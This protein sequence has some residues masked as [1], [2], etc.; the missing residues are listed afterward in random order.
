MA[1]E[2]KTARW[3]L[4]LGYTAFALVAFV[5]CLMFTFPYDAVRSRLVT[6]AA[7]QGL[8]VRIG[9]LRPGLS[10]V[11]ATNVRV[12]KPPSPLGADAVAALARGESGGMGPDELGEALTFDSVALRPSLFPPGVV[13]KLKGMGGTVNVHVGGLSGTA[14]DVDVDGVQAGGGNLPAYTGVDMEGT[15]NAKVSLQAPGTMVRGQPV[16]WSQATGTVVMDTQGLTIKGGKAAIPMGGGPAMPM[17]L[18]RVLLGELK[19]DIQFDK[20]LGTVRDLN[21]KSEDLEGSGTGT[22]KLGRRLEYSEL[23]LD[24][25]LKFEQAFQQRLG[26][27]A[28]AVN[29]LPADR[30]NPGW[31]G[32]RLT[33]MVGSPRFA[34][35]H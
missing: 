33:G 10:G 11:T 26:P 19:G 20:G 17:D 25:R 29:M 5:L 30:D 35:K 7:A 4:I 2:T 23:A 27:L 8:A 18:P 12:S 24:V 14:L 22:V 1:S 6:E 9:G 34:P 31:R 21:L 13:L 16:D 15:V 32:G 28:L 3:K